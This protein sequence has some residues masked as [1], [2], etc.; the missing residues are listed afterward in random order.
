MQCQAPGRGR[1][2]GWRL[3][4]PPTGRATAAIAELCEHLTATQTRYPGTDLIVH[5]E[6]K[7]RP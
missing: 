3:D 7:N 4:P 2:P 1:D 5:Y 6:V